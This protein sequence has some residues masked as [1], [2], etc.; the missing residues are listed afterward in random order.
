MSEMTEDRINFDYDGG[1]FKFAGLVLSNLILQILTLG[2]FRFWARTRERRFLWSHVSLGED[3]LEYTGKGSELFLGF[4][5][6]MVV[7]F[8]VAGI[9]QGLTIVAGSSV[10]GQIAVNLVYMTSLMFLVH[11]AVYRARRY[12]LT[13]TLWRGIR[14][15]L[16]GSSVRYAL[17]A[18]AWLPAVILSLGLAAPFM[19]VALM[20]REINN[21]HLGDRPFTFDGKARDLFAYWIVPWLMLL[22]FI[23]GYAG[24]IYLS[25]EV[26][27]ATGIDINNP[28]ASEPNLETM[29]TERVED[30]GNQFPVAFALLGIGGVLYMISVAWY[31]VREFRYLAGRISFEGMSFSSEIGLGR[32]AWIY[33]SYLFTAAAVGM[34]I[35]VGLMILALVASGVPLDPDMVGIGMGEMMEELD[36]DAQFFVIFGITMTIAI[37]L[38]TLSRVMVFHRL[39]RAVVSTLA[40]TGVQ[41][42]SQVTQALDSA[43]RLGEGLADAF[44]LGDF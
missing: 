8:P 18:L 2:I 28:E 1:T 42:F 10:A 4:L 13:R 16:M 33:V 5:I 41:D 44:D 20:D 37:L 21:M 31:R 43:P 22:V 32:V 36:D 15:T 12:R 17:V 29:D 25:F 11:L 23:A 7:L 39:A 38:Q 40:L 14:G 6:A 24:A 35:V 26:M 27:D 34:A 30:A 3:R 19:R 9:Y